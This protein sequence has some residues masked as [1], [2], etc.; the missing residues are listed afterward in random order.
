MSN[1]KLQELAPYLPYKVNVSDGRTPFELTEHNFTNV[2]RYI[3]KIHLR[4]MSELDSY[5][6]ILWDKKDE[7]VRKFMDLDFLERFNEL[8]ID[9][10]QYSQVDYLPVGL[11]N[12]L[13]KHHFDIF[14]LHKL[15]VVDNLSNIRNVKSI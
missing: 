10:I 6:K 1:F 7:E 2:Y 3:T 8:D 14:R 4:P 5:F 13:L 15:G 9:H 12:L 11:Y